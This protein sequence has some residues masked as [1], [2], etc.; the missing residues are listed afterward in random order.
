MEYLGLLFE[1]AFFVA[2][3]LLYLF[4]RGLFSFNVKNPSEQEAFRQ[5][6]K[7]WMRFLGLG[8]AAIMGLNLF[9]HVKQLLS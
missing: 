5:K 1:I 7:I 4:A 2:G 3:I 8:V 9:I 6:N